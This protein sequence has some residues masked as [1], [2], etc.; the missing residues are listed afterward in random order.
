L[1]G[2]QNF[3]I[4]SHNGNWRRVSDASIAIA[5]LYDFSLVHH[6]DAVRISNRGKPMSEACATKVVRY[7][8]VSQ[9]AEQGNI[10]GAIAFYRFS[11]QLNLV[12]QVCQ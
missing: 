8:S 3:K 2:K 7:I 10:L 12:V 11:L 9:N 4:V 5:L 6:V 1:A